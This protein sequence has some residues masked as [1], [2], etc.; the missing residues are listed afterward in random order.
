MGEEQ[1]SAIMSALGRLEEGVGNLKTGQATLFLKVDALSVHGCARGE[2]R[3]RSLDKLE[4]R[5]N[6]LSCGEQGVQGV[7][8]VQGEQGV[9]GQDGPRKVIKIGPLELDGYNLKDVAVFALLAGVAWTLVSAH[10][11]RSDGQEK[12]ARI[13]KAAA[14]VMKAAGTEVPK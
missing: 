2:E 12:L 10:M 7:Q 5:L 9:K 14:L 6:S 8:G 3:S 1:T 4:T 13:E 11:D